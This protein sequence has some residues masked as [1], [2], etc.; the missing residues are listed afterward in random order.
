M[1]F[2]EIWRL[3]TECIQ[4]YMLCAT[5]PRCVF[6]QRQKATPISL[7]PQ[8]V[9]YPHQVDKQPI[10]MYYAYYAPCNSLVRGLKNEAKALRLVIPCLLL[11]V[12]ANASAD[13]LP[14]RVVRLID[15][16]NSVFFIKV[17]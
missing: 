7:T 1:V 16:D 3:K 6:N 13:G 8:F 5:L 14:D 11:V 2:V 15:I 12:T 9:F 10:P 4:V 17:R